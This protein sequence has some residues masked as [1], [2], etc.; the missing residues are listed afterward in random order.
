[1]KFLAEPYQPAR[2]A[3]QALAPARQPGYAATDAQVSIAH[4]L[5]RVDTL[6]ANG[7]PVSSADADDLR[8]HVERAVELICPLVTGQD[9]DERRA[10]A[11]V[12]AW[13]EDAFRLLVGHLDI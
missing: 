10:N 8:A 1:M 13:T 6:T 12:R 7:R 3:V 5:M 4:I 2:A 11:E 9:A